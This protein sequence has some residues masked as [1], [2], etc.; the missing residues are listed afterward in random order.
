MKL[1]IRSSD[2]KP[3]IKIL[4]WGLPGSGKTHFGLSAPKPL[5]IDTERGCE[6][7]FN[8]FEFDLLSL[9]TLDQIELTVKKLQEGGY[10]SYETLVIDSLTGLE[11]L[12]VEKHTRGER[13]SLAEWGVIKPKLDKLM[14]R[15]VSLPLNLICT[16]RSQNM[17]D[18]RAFKLI[19][20]RPHIQ[21]NVSAY[22]FD[23]IGKL[24]RRN[25]QAPN[26]ALNKS[27][28]QLPQKIEGI[29][30]EK[31]QSLV[32]NKEAIR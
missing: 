1:L 2:M 11:G 25:G 20:T 10:E 18:T 3:K 23:I 6:A 29:S 7:F 22:Y 14:K 15:I 27:R 31:L 13:T 21:K 26:I 8:R 16:A 24:E 32:Y 9:P 28:F 12:Y 4:T 5:V 17:W 19:G 30:F